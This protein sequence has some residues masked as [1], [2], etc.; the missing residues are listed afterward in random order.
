MSLE[1]SLLYDPPRDS[2]DRVQKLRLQF[3]N[4]SD[5]LPSFFGRAGGPSWPGEKSDHVYQLPKS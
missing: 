1:L 4:L 2:D 3:S 5:N